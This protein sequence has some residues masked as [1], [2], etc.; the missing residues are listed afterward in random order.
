[1]PPPWQSVRDLR[2]DEFPKKDERFLP[3]EIARFGWNHVGHAFLHNIDFR[4]T[5]YLLQRDRHTNFSRQV[6]VVEVVRV[7]KAFMR[8]EFQILAAKGVALARREV[9]EMTS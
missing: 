8:H 5:R 1:M 3:A 2:F 9:R 7:S 6:R 4:S